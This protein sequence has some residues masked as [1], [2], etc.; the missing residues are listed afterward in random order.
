MA[1]WEPRLTA[2]EDADQEQVE[3]IVEALGE[4]RTTRAIGPNA[5]RIDMDPD[6]TDDS[7]ADRQTLEQDLDSIDADWRK[8]LRIEM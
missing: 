7:T 8:V 1:T 3:K 5:W 4:T 2:A 6:P